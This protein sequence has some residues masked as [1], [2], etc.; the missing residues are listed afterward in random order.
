M[1]K[2]LNCGKEVEDEEEFCSRKCKFLFDI[3]SLGKGKLVVTTQPYKPNNAERTQNM[4]PFDGLKQI[5][6]KSVVA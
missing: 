4:S 2:C 6:A 1:K 5:F 3:N